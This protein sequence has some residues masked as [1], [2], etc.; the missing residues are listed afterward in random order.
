[1]L[2]GGHFVMCSRKIDGVI[3]VFVTVCEPGRAGAATAPPRVRRGRQSAGGN[4][5]L[6]RFVVW[7]CFKWKI[8]EIKS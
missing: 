5:D 7:M 6:M 1:M 8:N 2:S 4:C 3:L